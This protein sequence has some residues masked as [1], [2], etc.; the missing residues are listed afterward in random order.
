MNINANK[1]FR[2]KISMKETFH[3][4][5]QEEKV[6]DIIPFLQSLTLEERKKLAPVIK[7]RTKHYITYKNGNGM[8]GTNNQFVII[9]I[10]GF[11]CFNFNEYKRNRIHISYLS[12][13]FIKFHE[14][15]Q[16]DLM[17]Q[18]NIDDL[19]EW[20]H[21]EWMNDFINNPRTNSNLQDFSYDEIMRWY[22]K[23]YIKLTPE[24]ITSTLQSHPFVHIKYNHDF[25]YEMRYNKLNEYPE[26][27]SEHI[28]LF[29]LYPTNINYQ[30]YYGLENDDDNWNKIFRQLVA[31]GY[32]NR[33]RLLK[34]CLM[35]FGN[36][37]FNK[38]QIN[39]FVDLYNDLQPTSEELIALQNELLSSLTVTESK[40]IIC[41]LTYI[42]E[43]CTEPQFAVNEF[44]EM[45]SMLLS[46]PTK[47]IINTT[48]SICEKLLKE[49]PVLR[50][51]ICL[52]LTSGFISTDESTQKKIAKLLLK[53]GSKEQLSGHL[54]DYSGHIL[55]S[56]KELLKDYMD[57]FQENISAQEPGIPIMQVHPALPLIGTENII[58]VVETFEDFLFFAGQVFDNNEPWHIFML[59]VYVQKFHHILTED[60]VA[61]LEP[62]FK[63]AIKCIDTWNSKIGLTDR[64]FATFFLSYG[65]L[66]I[67]KFPHA[68]GYLKNMKKEYLLGKDNSMDRMTNMELYP[69]YFILLKT[70]DNI[71]KGTP[72][73]I[74]STPTHAPLWIDP[75]I[76][77]KRLS[78]YQQQGK[79]P[80]GFD[81]QLAILRCALDDTNEALQLAHT[82][83]SGELRDLF[84]YLFTP[85]AQAPAH[86]KH[87]AWWMCASIQKSP[88]TVPTEA[89]QWGF[90]KLFQE[91]LTG[92][93]KWIVEN[94][95]HGINTLK[96]KLPTYNL[97]SH[98]DATFL[99][100]FYY[101]MFRSRYLWSGDIQRII[102]SI[103]YNPD[104]I[105]A[106]FIN[107][108]RDYNAMDSMEKG[109][110]INSLIALINLKLPLSPMGYLLLSLSLFAPN[111]EIRDYAASL[112]M[113]QVQTGLL[114]LKY[115]GSIMAQ[116][117]QTKWLPLKRF[118]D[119]IETNM[120]HISTLHNQS[121]EELLSAFFTAIGEKKLTNLKKLQEIYNELQ[122]VNSK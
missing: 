54:S 7:E 3:R 111:K 37:A 105:I 24:L 89:K 30:I 28:W 79:S 76:L 63:Q 97:K 118:I 13:G 113:Q 112:W 99:P 19:L 82:E 64:I 100:E 70:L 23:G 106:H 68:S 77:I 52:S 46:L 59:P 26:T 95:K 91:Y 114:D 88:H 5:L 45:I 110:M 44:Q 4:I 32:I 115:L 73:D 25:R 80:Y 108:I 38:P 119:V 56:V 14:Y 41:A 11:V 109:G 50:E 98:L 85:E 86:V 117:L 42:K 84:I 78:T 58:P 74:L 72:V 122:A 90:E 92:D 34:E 65:K 51:D 33:L 20:H 104:A 67:E 31:D 49:F 96:I 39:W 43:I 35:T 1:T 101:S 116:L 60:K 53:Y 81:I 75:K 55:S 69:F 107:Y 16:K 102:S 121:L 9:S 10:A 71:R 61:Q 40:P 29:F 47:G 94:N 6:N 120:L 18:I 17:E 93:F 2:C 83:L 57:V 62:I 27:L 36:P 15:S 22:A 12:S 66:L 8:Y 103:P 21:P 87:P 48:I